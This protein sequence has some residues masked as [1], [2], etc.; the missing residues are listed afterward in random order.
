MA[1]TP[2]HAMFQF[3]VADGRLSCQLY[4]RSADIFLGV[5]FNIASYSL[6]THMMAQQCG[7]DVGEFIWTGGD[8]HLYVNHVEQARLQ[9]TREPM[10]LPTLLIHR[11][12]DSIFDYRFE[13]FEV[14][15]YQSHPPIK[16][17]IAV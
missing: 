11:C 1:L 6:L 9:L 10:P 5:P 2:C 14:S 3:Y 17:P 13:D 7:L 4:Q 16:A 15:G 8:C 12:P